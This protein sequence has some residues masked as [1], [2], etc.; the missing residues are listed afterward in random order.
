[1]PR[2]VRCLGLNNRTSV[3]SLVP[4]T[5]SAC[6]YVNALWLSWTKSLNTSAE[7][8]ND[9][10]IRSGAQMG[11]RKPASLTSGQVSRARWHSPGIVPYP[12]VLRKTPE[13]ALD[14]VS[15]IVADTVQKFARDHCAD[16][17]GPFSA[18]L[19]AY[20]ETAG[21]LQ[22]GVT[23]CTGVL[24]R[25]IDL[26]QNRNGF[27]LYNGWAGLGWLTTNLDVEDDFVAPY[28]DQLLVKALDRP[29]VHFGYDLISG[30]VGVGA[31]FV[32]RL[33]RESAKRGLRL[34]LKALEETAV[35]TAIGTTWFTPPDCLPQWQ[36][37]R[38][39][40][41]YYNLGVAH[42]LPGV[43]WLLAKLCVAGIEAGRAA[44]LLRRSLRWLQSKQPEPTRPNLPS[45]ISPGVEPEPNQ[46]MAWC[47]GP[48]GASAVAL[49]AARSIGDSEG[50]E[51]ARTL[52][53]ACADIPPHDGQIR[54][55]GLCHGAAGNAHIF[56]RLSRSDG[57]P[58]FRQAANDWLQTTLAY[59]QH[60]EGVGG[61]R[62]WGD[63]SGRQEWVDDA[64]FLTG[65]TGVGLA[66]LAAVTSVEPKWDRLLL[67]S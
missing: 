51:W 23:R 52:A 19:F 59:R 37:E 53:L 30:L 38:A 26:E 29:A 41:G 14:A 66:L 63:V 48:L 45:W 17:W 8:A 35:K 31:Y 46:R 12:S 6:G 3:G 67:L 64:S 49:D 4:T 56:L 11:A 9:A 39:P 44:S 21:L 61:Y 15:A 42:G 55:A 34:V 13:R 27:S 60:G 28:V 57:H 62:M 22:D 65:S 10:D 40:K 7:T 43:C 47:Y 32:E 50:V 33:P 25:S 18:L 1:M 24:E 36:R 58:K 2:F 16:T 5:R 20:C 54:D